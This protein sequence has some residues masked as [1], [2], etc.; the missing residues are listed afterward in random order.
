MGKRGKKGERGLVLRRKE[1]GGYKIDTRR[2]TTILI[3]KK[4]RNELARLKRSK[5]DTYEGVIW[6]LIRNASSN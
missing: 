2:F 4:L 1:G 5:A 3:T 6:E